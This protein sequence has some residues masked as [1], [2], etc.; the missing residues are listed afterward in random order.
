VLAGLLR[1]IIPDATVVSVATADELAQ[2]LE[3]A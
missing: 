1:R 2:L 3:A